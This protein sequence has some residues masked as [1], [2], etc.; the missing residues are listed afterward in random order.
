MEQMMDAF[1]ALCLSENDTD[2]LFNLEHRLNTWTITTT[3]LNYKNHKILICTDEEITTWNGTII[4]KGGFIY[5][6]YK[7]GKN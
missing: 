6:M 3:N 5:K 2:P 7:L 1:K 4:P